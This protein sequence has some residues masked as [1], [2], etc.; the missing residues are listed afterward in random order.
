MDSLLIGL[1]KIPTI[2]LEGLSEAQRKAYVIADNQIALN[3]GWNKDNLRLEIMDLKKLDFNI[4]VMG[5][6]I[7]EIKSLLNDE[8]KYS[9]KVEAPIYEPSEKK[10][11]FNE[12]FDSDKCFELIKNIEESNI[13]DNEK[14]F[15]TL[16]AY[17]H[18]S[19]NFENIANY[20]AHANKMIQGLME[21]SALV[22]IDYN[23]AIEKGYV[24]FSQRISEQYLVDHPHE[25]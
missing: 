17:R 2:M 15:L 11:D 10:P 13:S 9:E 5:F 22:I 1:E 16:A 7:A 23:K 8:D 3:A 24:T 14:L 21:E 20:Y 18:V 25:E 19:F 4:K 6:E 12:L